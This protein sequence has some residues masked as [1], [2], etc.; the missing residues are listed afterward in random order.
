M[1]VPVAVVWRPPGLHGRASGTG[2]AGGGSMLSAEFRLAWPRTAATASPVANK[3]TKNARP[4]ASARPEGSPTAGPSSLAC[5]SGVQRPHAMGHCAATR[6]R[7]H[8]ARRS[9]RL[10]DPMLSHWAFVSSQTTG[11]G[12]GDGG[13]SGMRLHTVR[14]RKAYHS[15]PPG[16]PMGGWQACRGRRVQSDLYSMYTVRTVLS[17]RMYAWKP[18]HR[19]R[20]LSQTCMLSKGHRR[21]IFTR[22][23]RLLPRTKQPSF[24]AYWV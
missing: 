12:G 1:R 7:P 16:W 15:P 5:E 18:V 17:G 21:F 3:Q 13:G 4:A 9:A 23:I 24:T 6:L 8:T 14:R 11:P 20:I 19:G 10:M 2:R 22:W